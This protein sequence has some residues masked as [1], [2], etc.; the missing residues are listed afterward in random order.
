MEGIQQ[1]DP[2]QPI[3]EMEISPEERERVLKQIEEAIAENR[4]P[5]RVDLASLQPEKRGLL[6]PLLINLAALVLIAAGVLLLFRYF[7][8]RKENITLRHT[9]YLSA[10]GALIQTLK[11]ETESRL[12]AKEQQIA[13]IQTRLQEVDQ[14]RQAL[15]LEL[16]AQLTTRE[17]E[18]LREL[19]DELDRERE[20]LLALGTSEAGITDRLREFKSRQQDSIDREIADYRRQ[21]DAQ[22]QDKER[23]LLET[24]RLSRE[25]LD[26]ANRDRNALLSEL[27]KQESEKSAAEERLTELTARLQAESLMRDQSAAVFSAVQEDLLARR[28]A[29]ALQELESLEN[30][31]VVEKYVIDLLKQLIRSSQ[32]QASQGQSGGEVESAD[33]DALK[34]ELDAKSA[35]IE[36]MEGQIRAIVEASSSEK[37]ADALLAKQLQGRVDRL[38]AQLKASEAQAEQLNAELR[39]LRA[40]RDALSSSQAST[41]EQGRDEALRDVMTFLRFLSASEGSGSDTEKQLLALTRRDPLFRAATREIQILIAGGGS[42]GELASPY[43]FLGIVSSVTS[44]RVVIEA[45]VDLEVSVGSIIQIRRITEQEREITIAEGTVQQV[46][47]GKITASFKPVASGGQGPNARDPVYMV[48]EGT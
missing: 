3:E 1:D 21:L 34:A 25:A 5:Q 15:K 12:Q 17:G 10:E 35:Q 42:S 31:P 28:Y 32:G 13:L 6:L 7:E 44:E 20:R 45:M 47:G 11:K 24:Q 23:E 43:L 22:L 41:F 30:N 2:L 9:S 26:K 16:E 18:L 36:Q 46:R 33:L 19:E 14:E 8:L 4:A 48:L 38:N 39:S 37:S 27:K 40:E 29:E